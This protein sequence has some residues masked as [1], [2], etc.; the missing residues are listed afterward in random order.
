MEPD[1]FEWLH[2]E[3]ARVARKGTGRQFV[4]YQLRQH[5]LRSAGIFGVMLPLI[6]ILAKLPT[7][8]VGSL[9][10]LPLLVLGLSTLTIGAVALWA[11][12]SRHLV[13][14]W[15]G[16]TA[17]GFGALLAIGSALV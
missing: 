1:R 17:I 7:Q 5:Y 13:G 4:Q 12:A 16:W 2:Q 14:W 3:Q 8:P 6:L 10:P 15:A 11:G 9:K